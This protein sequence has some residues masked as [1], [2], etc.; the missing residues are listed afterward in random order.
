MPNNNIA[1]A[2]LTWVAE[3]NRE[4]A[5]ACD[6]VI[7]MLKQHPELDE[8]MVKAFGIQPPL[9]KDVPMG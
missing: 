3:Y 1:I 7:S 6:K 8:Y 5:D 4:I 9:P 2:K